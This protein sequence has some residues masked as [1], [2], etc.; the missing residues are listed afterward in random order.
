MA[1]A[2]TVLALVGATLLSAGCA[3]PISVAPDIAKLER[4]STAPPRITANVGYFIAPEVSSAEITTQGG[5]GDNV[6]YFPYRDIEA[7][8]QKM[9]SNVFTGV[10]KLT[11]PTA[12]ENGSEHIDYVVLP[13]IVTS[14]GGSGFFTWPPTNFTVDLTCSIRDTVGT[15]IATTRVVGTGTADTSERI[16]DHGFAGERA[17]EDALMKMQVA[18]FEIKLPTNAPTI[19]AIPPQ[20]PPMPSAAAN[21][22][23]QLKDLKDRGLISEAEYEA[24]RKAILDTL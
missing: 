22:L 15:Q 24:K 16:H 13:T 18:L 4:I 21:R 8:Y 17:M 10:V 2:S 6:R 1:N 20:S 23:V 9:L 12:L 11:S 5:G 3:H 19:R 14:S 7:G